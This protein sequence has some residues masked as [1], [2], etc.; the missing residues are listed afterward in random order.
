MVHFPSMI[1]FFK[2][3]CL[4]LGAAIGY[5]IV[6]D[7]ITAR[8]C[9][10]YFTVAHP[11]VFHTTSPTLLALGWG[12]I[13]TG[14]V[15]VILGLPLA[16]VSRVGRV[17]RI[18]AGDLVWPVLILL[19]CMA[20][21]A[22]AAGTYGWGSTANGHESDLVRYFFPYL[23]PE[24]HAR[25]AA[26]AYAHLASYGSGFIGGIVLIIWTLVQRFRRGIAAT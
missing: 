26:D 5:G 19:G 18:S 4:S 12:V 25:F 2:I 22:L 14:W 15:G 24:K 17:R 23:P 20:L 21:S 16:A 6:H 9:V 7:Q 8:I 13:A 11:P 10:E 3:L 1:E